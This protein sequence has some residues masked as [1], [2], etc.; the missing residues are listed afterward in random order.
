MTWASL[1]KVGPARAVEPRLTLDKIVQFRRS[2]DLD[3]HVG[4]TR[5]ISRSGLLFS[6][7]AYLP[8]GSVI[9]VQL[10]HPDGHL[11]FPEA[12]G[13][14]LGQVVRRVLMSWPEVVPLFAIQFTEGE[15]TELNKLSGA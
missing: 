3:W 12:G 11:C 5:N 13:H 7:S 1:P 4:R 15:P 6:S 14:C 2:G 10:R 8:V 9:E